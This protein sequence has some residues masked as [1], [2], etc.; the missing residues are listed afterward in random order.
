MDCDAVLTRCFIVFY[1]YCTCISHRP[2]YITFKCKT[3]SKQKHFEVVFL[4]ADGPWFWRSDETQS[5]SGVMLIV[6]SLGPGHLAGLRHADGQQ[7]VIVWTDQNTWLYESQ[8]DIRCMLAFLWHIDSWP[9]HAKLISWS[10]RSTKGC[11]PLCYMI[12]STCRNSGAFTHFKQTNTKGNVLSSCFC[13]YK[14]TPV[15]N[16]WTNKHWDC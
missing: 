8:L 13:L 12:Y 11:D 15:T 5:G 4:D 16:V 1:M 9:Q 7:A 14:W 6:L 10:E 3:K 2:N